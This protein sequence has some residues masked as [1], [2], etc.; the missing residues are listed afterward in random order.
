[1]I[2]WGYIWK[3]VFVLFLFAGLGVFLISKG[4]KEE[5]SYTNNPSMPRGCIISL[6][7]AF[8]IPLIAYL[9]LLW[10]GRP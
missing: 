8:I 9:V 4:M 6:G 10:L 5:S 1:M 3:A 2:V 7:F